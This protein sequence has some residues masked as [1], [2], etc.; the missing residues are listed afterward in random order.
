MAG[1]V[2]DSDTP[3]HGHTRTRVL[4]FLRMRI[5]PFSGKWRQKERSS[6]FEKGEIIEL[7]RKDIEMESSGVCCT[8]I[9]TGDESEDG[10]NV[11][12]TVPLPTPNYS[13]P[14]PPVTLVQVTSPS[15]AERRNKEET[16]SF[17]DRKGVEDNSKL[18][19]GDTMLTT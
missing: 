17:E 13:Y 4:H 11:N 14:A 2:H 8:I 9:S 15:S 3:R 1:H 12:L 19:Q 10:T 5:V 7:A 18:K 6:Q 16:P